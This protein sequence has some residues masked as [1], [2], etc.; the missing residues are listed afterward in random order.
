MPRGKRLKGV[1]DNML[2]TFMSR[3][4]D[5]G[6]YWGLGVLRLEMDRLELNR[7]EFD[8]LDPKAE[9]PG[10]CE[11]IGDWSR[12]RFFRQLVAH[13]VTPSELYAASITIMLKEG[14]LL[15]KLA[16][17]RGDP[18]TCAVRCMDNHEREFLARRWCMC[19]PHD[20]L[21]ELK[22]GGVK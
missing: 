20:P 12:G 6:G 11:P 7:V 13:S 18:M 15:E 14:E 8:L 2:M 16:G 21:L 22:R 19:A 5:V 1:A 4:N 9:F 3:Y 17:G 10:R